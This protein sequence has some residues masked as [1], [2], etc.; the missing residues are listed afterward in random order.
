MKIDM[1]A[2]EIGENSAIKIQSGNTR[3]RNRVAAH[4]HK[5]IGASGINHPLEQAVQLKGIRGSVCRS[6]RLVFNIVHHSREQA[7]F[8]SQPAY[9]LIQQRGNRGFSV[10]S[11]HAN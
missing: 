3:L 6:H 8:I 7:G 11:R 1:V 9:Q 4:F 5:S 2:R 10:G